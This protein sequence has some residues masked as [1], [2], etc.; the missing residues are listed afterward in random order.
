MTMRALLVLVLITVSFSATAFAQT[1]APKAAKPKGQPK[2][3]SQMGCK[4]VGTIKGT[5]IWAGDCM[6]AAGLRG[7][8]PA[9]EAAAPSLP[10]QPAG[11]IPPDQKQ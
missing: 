8:A 7:A 10:D 2:P 6:D 5:K 11:A 4:L 1:P 9:S 3:Q